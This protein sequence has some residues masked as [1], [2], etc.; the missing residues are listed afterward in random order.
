MS[1]LASCTASTSL[2]YCSDSADQEEH[3]RLPVSYLSFFNKRMDGDSGS[4]CCSIKLTIDSSPTE[5]PALG[6]DDAAGEDS[7]CN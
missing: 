2:D 3:A 6:D 5:I 1:R 7:Q 4:V